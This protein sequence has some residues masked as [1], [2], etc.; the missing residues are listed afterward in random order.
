MTRATFGFV[1]VF[2]FVFLF[3]AFS[4]TACSSRRSRGAASSPLSPIVSVADAKLASQL[5]SG[6]YA[7]EN[8]A[9]RWTAPK[10]SFDLQAPF[11]A[12][13]RGAILFIRGSVPPVAVEKLGGQ[14]VACEVG[15]E[16]LAPEKLTRVGPFALIRDV[17]P[18]DGTIV[19]V[20]CNV[21][22]FLAPGAN[23]KRE[24]GVIV[25]SMALLP[26]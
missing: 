2:V 5:V 11:G 1:F 25:S 7:L 23:D 4:T 20:H 14:S 17:S 12:S 22:P 10:F 9:W 19:T 3:L 18:F 21:D 15:T 13:Q 26:R 16:S 8:D 24:L 6:F